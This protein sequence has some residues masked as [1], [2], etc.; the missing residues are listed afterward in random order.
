MVPGCASA[1]AAHR[2]SLATNDL[3][4]TRV[5]EDSDVRVNV[6]IQ[7]AITRQVSA[8]SWTELIRTRERIADTI[9]GLVR[10]APRRLS[11][12]DHLKR[13]TEWTTMPWQGKERIGRAAG[14]HPWTENLEPGRPAASWDVAPSEDKL[15]TSL[16]SIVTA[17]QTLVEGPPESLEHTRLSALVGTAL[18]KLRAR[19]A[20][21]PRRSRQAAR[22]MSTSDWRPK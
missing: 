7:A 2:G 16:S 6:G 18:K 9:T 22:P 20:P 4:A 19:P 14:A 12:H 1:R 11:A 13:R 8:Y 5:R 15:T 17:L 10:S 21:I 3:A